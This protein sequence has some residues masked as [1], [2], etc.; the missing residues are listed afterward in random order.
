MDKIVENSDPETAQI[1]I[2]DQGK[3]KIQMLIDWSISA[4]L[5]ANKEYKYIC[6]RAQHFNNYHIEIAVEN[7]L[8][9]GYEQFVIKLR[10]MTR[11]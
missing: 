6:T 4:G 9:K 7:P 3:L 1:H 5:L 10:R 8:L 11:D 2:V